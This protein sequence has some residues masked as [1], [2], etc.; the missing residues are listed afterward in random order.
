MVA[1]AVVLLMAAAFVPMAR[2]IYP[3]K[4][5]ELILK[6]AGRRELD[7]ALLAAIVY[8]ESKF[9]RASRSTAGAVGLMQLMPAT[10]GW[11]AKK[12]GRPELAADLA[13]PS[14]NLTLGSWYFKYLLDRYG[15]EALALAAYN[16]GHRNLDR[17]LAEN[18]GRPRAAVIDRIPFAETKAFV[19]QVQKSRQVY[20]WLYPELN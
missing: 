14:A 1:I 7:P 19:R 4:Y 8:E 15:S 5:E 18:D 20:Q 9:S 2:L 10:A 6:E 16:G 11:A 17:W 13:R 12:M 3:L